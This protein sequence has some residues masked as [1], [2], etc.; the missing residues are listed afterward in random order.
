[1][2]FNDKLGQY[3]CENNGLFFA[4]DEEPEDDITGVIN[5]LTENYYSHLDEIVQFMLPDIKLIYG[6]VDVDTVKKKLGKPIIDYDNGR[7][8]Y[9]EQEFDGMHIFEF[10]FFDDSFEELQ[11]F[12]ID[13]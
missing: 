4:W 2:D 8:T 11:N 10:E 9:Y 3:L 6:D 1:M 5:M 12:S 13:G 7:V